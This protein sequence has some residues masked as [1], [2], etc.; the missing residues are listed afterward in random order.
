MGS[1]YGRLAS[2]TSIVA[3]LHAI[4]VGLEILERSRN[5]QQSSWELIPKRLSILQKDLI[6]SCDD[7][8]LASI[9]EDIRELL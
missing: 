4:L 8:P 5:E 7:H 2:C 6:T 3:E 9:M 1:Y